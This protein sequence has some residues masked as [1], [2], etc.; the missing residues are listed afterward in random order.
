MIPYMHMY[1]S[2]KCGD[3]CRLGSKQGFNYKTEDWGQALLESEPEGVNVILDCVG[4]F[5]LCG[6]Y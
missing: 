2:N 1:R 6:L 5:C 4:K 3:T